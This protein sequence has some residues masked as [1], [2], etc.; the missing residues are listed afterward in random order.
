MTTQITIAQIND[1]LKSHN[2]QGYANE[3]QG[4][5][6]YINLS[7]KNNESRGDRNYQ[8]YIDLA[9][10]ELVSKLGKGLTTREFDSAVKAFENAFNAKDNAENTAPVESKETEQENKQET[11]KLVITKPTLKGSEKQIAWA[12]EIINLFIAK[13]GDTSIPVTATQEQIKQAQAMVDNFFAMTNAGKWIEKFK[14]LND[15]SEPKQ[16]WL[17]VKYGW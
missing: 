7:A 15:N 12:D 11:T 2:I 16:F 14:G 6:I 3:W 4:R 5:R 1:L 17:S 9:T 13:I 10:G 8:L